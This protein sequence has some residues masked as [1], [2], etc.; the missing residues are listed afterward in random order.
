M[1]I[2]FSEYAPD[3]TSLNNPGSASIQNCIPL[4][5][6]YESF[7]TAQAYSSNGL[8]ARCQGAY[9][10]RDFD[11]NIFHFAGDAT[12]LYKL[13]GL[14]WG[15]ISGATYT[16]G[17]DERWSFMQYG[18]LVVATNFND[19]P[20]SFLMGTSSVF[21]NL[22]GSPPKGR[23][24]AQI[25]NFGFLANLENYPTRIQ[26]SALNDLEDWTPDVDT[27]AGYV[28][29][30][31]EYGQITQIVGGEFGIVFQERAITKLTYVGSPEWFQVDVIETGRGTQAP[32][33]VCKIG[34][35]IYYF[36]TDGFYALTGAGSIPIGENK[37]DKTFLADLDADYVHRMS[38]A[39]DPKKSIVYFGAPSVQSSDGSNYRIWPYNY[40]VNR[41]TRNTPLPS[42]G[43]DVLHQAFSGGLTL[44]DLDSISSSIDDL[45]YSLD[46][47]LWTGGNINL[48]CFDSS[49]NKLS[50]FNGEP[51][52]V[53]ATY[54]LLDTKAFQPNPGHRTAVLELRPNV[55]FDDATEPD[56]AL[57]V[58]TGDTGFRD[59]DLGDVVIDLAPNSQGYFKTRLNSNIY[60]FRLAMYGQFSYATGIEIT[61]MRVAGRR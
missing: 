20:Q 30:N 4:G 14:A 17:A 16:T 22:A 56:Y 44:E 49:N 28:D 42:G 24:C 61:E 11:G 51:G 1:F 31:P 50:F 2:A 32:G 48:A 10:T 27:G 53:T 9:C 12:K 41:W 46:S 34:N 57:T 15:D 3:L 18:N 38:S 25:K 54:A 40:S 55:S 37:V 13:T 39:A 47:S 60:K 35:V 58:F 59:S 36:G 29:L 19:A 52:A 45:P 26:R 6:G 7:P 33:S 21:G 43:F 8:T 5:E 23:Y